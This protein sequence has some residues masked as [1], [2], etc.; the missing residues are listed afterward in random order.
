[1][2]EIIKVNLYTYIQTKKYTLYF[3]TP[4]DRHGGGLKIN[5]SHTDMSLPD[6]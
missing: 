3:M 1:M 4:N 5:I 2:K 6:S